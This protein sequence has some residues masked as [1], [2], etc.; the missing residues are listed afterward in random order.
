LGLWGACAP[1]FLSNLVHS[2]WHSWLFVPN[3]S[4]CVR[5]SWWLPC[6]EKPVTIACSSLSFRGK[7]Y[8]NSLTEFDN[9]LNPPPNILLTWPPGFLLYVFF[10]ITV[11]KYFQSGISNVEILTTNTT[12]YCRF[13]R[14]ASVSKTVSGGSS[15]TFNL[16]TTPFHLLVAKG[17]ILNGT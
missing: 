15:K 1:N 16:A 6:A 5:F 14:V 9:M 2:H 10:T 4:L 17:P 13:R 8:R 3:W 12:R 7:D 11:F